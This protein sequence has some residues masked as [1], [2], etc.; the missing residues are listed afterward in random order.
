M[1]LPSGERDAFLR[2]ECAADDELR[3]EVERLISSS[4]S[5]DNFIESPI[6]TDS[7]FL[8]TSAKKE[9]SESIKI[10][11][12]DIDADNLIGR[13]IGVYRLT[14]EI[15]RGGISTPSAMTRVTLSCCVRPVIPSSNSS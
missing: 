13:E 8:N 15:G 14:R 9:I 7:S 1:D 10:D 3:R 5:A 2:A 4:E 6:W 12:T 11:G